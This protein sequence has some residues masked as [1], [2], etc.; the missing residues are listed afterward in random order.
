MGFCSAIV[1]NWIHYLTMQIWLVFTQESGM[2]HLS[3]M[4]QVAVAGE[5]YAT[6]GKREMSIDQTFGLRKYIV[7]INFDY[8]SLFLQTVRRLAI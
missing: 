6:A 5:C 3:H 2:S 4:A 1:L 8:A 7:Y